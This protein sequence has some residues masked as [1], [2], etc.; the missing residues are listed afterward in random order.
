MGTTLTF[1]MIQA[2]RDNL[3]GII[4]ETDLFYA[5]K[6]SE[7]TGVALHLKLE[8]LQKAGSFKIR[9]AYNKMLHLS[10]AE[11]AAGVVASS[12]GNHAQGVAISATKL[13]IKSTIVMPKNAPFAKISATK[14]NGAHVVLEGYGYDE[15][16]EKA[17]IIQKETGATFVHPFNDPYV[18]AGQ[19]TIAFEMLEAQPDLDVIIVPIGGGGLAAGVALAA[20]QIKPSIRI[21]GVQS[22]NAPAM[23]EALQSD[24]L[25]HVPVTRTIAD[26]IAIAHPGELTFPLIQTYV[27]DIMTVSETQL[28]EAFLFLL[29]SCNL[30]CEGAGTVSVAA[31]INNVERFKGQQVGAVLS[32]GNIDIN[33]IESVINHALVSTGR[34]TQ[35]KTVVSHQPGELARLFACIS[36]CGGNVLSIYQNRNRKGL[37][38]Y[39]MGVTLVIEAIDASHKAAIFDQL[40]HHGYTFYES[41]TQTN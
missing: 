13:G 4:K 21:I 29:E 9:G 14:N 2:A 10:E 12:A 40:T 17:K 39:Q 33:L 27:D 20:K 5:E 32:G 16:Y 8:N 11:K 25:E 24:K 34:R 15:A 37:S 31:L 6:F 26:G 3:Q 23:Y 18:I 41:H 28:S 1:D 38:M 19:G 7:E 30:V 22:E 36:E 35:I